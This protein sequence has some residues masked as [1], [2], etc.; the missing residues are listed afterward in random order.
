MADI[1]RV[2][3]ASPAQ[4]AAVAAGAPGGRPHDSAVH[5][6]AHRAL[7]PVH[8]Y[9]HQLPGAGARTHHIL[10]ASTL[11]SAESASARQVRSGVVPRVSAVCAAQERG[12]VVAPHA[13]GRPAHRAARPLRRGQR[14]PRSHSA[15]AVRRRGE[16][17]LLREAEQS[18]QHHDRAQA[19]VVATLASRRLQRH[20]L[21]D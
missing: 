6:R 8:R 15:A 7:L 5:P 18:P 10:P 20:R 13:S 16:D 9:S 11:G 19:P 12:H 2:S 4:Y 17:W 3:D 21:Y 14:L 1:A